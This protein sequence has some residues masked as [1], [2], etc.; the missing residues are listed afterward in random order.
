MA[1]TT[2]QP[3]RIL[4]YL[5]L[6]PMTTRTPLLALTVIPEPGTAA[7]SCSHAAAAPDAVA[8]PGWSF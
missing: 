3:F 4:P 2:D 1:R 8:G 6:I 5:P 7:A